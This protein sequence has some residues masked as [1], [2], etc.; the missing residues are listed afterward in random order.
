LQPVDECIFFHKFLEEENDIDLSGKK[1]SMPYD[2]GRTKGEE[3]I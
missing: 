3:G 2:P 1:L